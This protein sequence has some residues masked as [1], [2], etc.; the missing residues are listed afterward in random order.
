MHLVRGLP[1]ALGCSRKSVNRQRRVLL[2]RILLTSSAIGTVESL[3]RAHATG[4]REAIPWRTPEELVQH[5]FRSSRVVMLNEAHSG[6]KRCIRTRE[7]GVRAVR[8]AHDNGVR[9][10]AMEALYPYTI[11]DQS[12]GTRVA[13]VVGGG[14]LAQQEMRH[15]IQTALDLGWTLVPYEAEVQRQPQRLSDA[16]RIN[17][18]ERE[19]ALQLA[20]ALDRLPGSGKLLVWCGNSHLAEIEMGNWTPMGYCFRSMSGIDPFTIDQCVTVEFPGVPRP[21]KEIAEVHRQALEQRGGTAGFLRED[22]PAS[23]RGR[24]ESDALILSVR[25]SLE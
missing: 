19:Q 25:N 17:W 22:D 13:P 20:A 10:L 11:A 3:P 2:R 1:T 5:G 21:Y 9:H 12:N 15:L 18:R 7:I 16:E 14:Y 24:R 8:V 6:L 4:E 23:N